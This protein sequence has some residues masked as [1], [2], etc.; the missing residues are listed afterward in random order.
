MSDII[1]RLLGIEKEA[2]SI[3]ARAEKDAAAALEDAREEAG[4]TVA[5]GHKQAQD[6]AARLL[7]RQSDELTRQRDDRLR[8][9]QA[10]LPTPESVDSGKLRR[11]VEF[12]VRVVAYG[13]STG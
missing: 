10:K 3:I 13:E 11:A 7:Q 5:Q 2:R 8:Q 12:V 9:E 6:E 4:R 1:D